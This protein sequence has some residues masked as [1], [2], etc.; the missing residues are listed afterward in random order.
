MSD[1]K[2]GCAKVCGHCGRVT[3][4]DLSRRFCPVTAWNISF[5]K[6]A[7][8]CRFYVSSDDD[9]NRHGREDDVL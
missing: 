3:K 6:P 5:N 7:D 8:G 9:V 2:R 4:I 1:N